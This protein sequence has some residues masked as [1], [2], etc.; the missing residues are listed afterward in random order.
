MINIHFHSDCP[1]FGGCEH[2][3]TNLFNS[4]VIRDTS[5]VS[6]SY[7]N[8]PK[9]AEGFF[10]R[11]KREVRLYPLNFPDLS[12]YSQAPE[13]L[14]VTVR[15]FIMAG[16]RFLFCPA[17][18]VYEIVYLTILFRRLDVDILHINNGNYPGALSGRAAAIAGKMAG[19]NHI[20]MVVN[21]L[22]FGYGR[23]SRM[24]DYPVDRL[25]V[26]CVEQ[27]I[28]GSKAAAGRL[29]NVLDLPDGKVIAVHNGIEVCAGISTRDAMKASYGLQGFNGIVFGCVAYFESRKGHEFL[30]RAVADAATKRAGL[31][32]QLKVLLIGN[33]PQKSFL[34]Q[35]VGELN[36][37]ALVKFI[38]VQDNYADY[39][40]ALDVVVLPSIDG[41]DF[42][43]VILEAMAT[44]RPVIATNI[45]GIPEQVLHGET[46]LLV[47][48]RNI[49]QLEAAI[50]CLVDDPGLRTKM[51]VAARERFQ[52]MFTS[53]IAVSA[54]SKIYRRMTGERS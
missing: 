7:R 22:A 11:L 31:P 41:E 51:G 18:V 30:L 21:N 20:I 4:D 3:L 50:F 8:S 43:N 10:K 9:Y 37:E 25:V 13:Q 52:K 46:G 24:L 48:P 47:E 39:M 28:T 16:I 42:P 26:R 15:R 54:Y 38:D 34:Q 40:S 14:P 2:M 53:S 29:A 23:F 36:I 44:E 27:F 35:L 5:V 49:E 17:L 12:G 6:F 32:E 1:Y 33:G 45:A 19:I